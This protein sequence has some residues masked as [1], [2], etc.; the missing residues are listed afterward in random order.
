V[1]GA[2]TPGSGR[3]PGTPNKT[4]REIRELAK[5]YGPGSLEFYVRV[6]DDESL[7]IMA[8]LYAA[9]RLLDRGYGKPSRILELQARSTVDYSNMTDAELAERG[10]RLLEALRAGA[11]TRQ[12]PAAP[13]ADGEIVDGGVVLPEDVGL[14]PAGERAQEGDKP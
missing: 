12:L 8:R 13:V 7:P 14:N 6:R 5:Q 1:H 9:D 11:A 4:T 10:E 2:K 3:K